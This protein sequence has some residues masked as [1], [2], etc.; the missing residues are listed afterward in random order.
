VAGSKLQR[1]W[2]QIAFPWNTVVF[3]L[4]LNLG[5]ALFFRVIDAYHAAGTN[6]VK[7]RFGEQLTTGRL[8]KVY[9]GMSEPQ[10]NDLLNETW[11]R[12][13]IYEPFTGFTEAVHEGEYVNV[14][15]NGYRVGTDQGPWPPQKQ[16]QLVIFLF[17]GSTTFSYGVPDNLALGSRLQDALRTTLGRPVAVYNFGRG[18]YYSTQERIL[19]EQLVSA[20]HVPDVAIF[21]DG[22]NDFYHTQI[23]LSFKPTGLISGA[24]E[25]GLGRLTGKIIT[26]LAIAGFARAIRTWLRG[27]VSKPTADPVTLGK[28]QTPPDESK[29]VM[30]TI[31]RYFRN[32]AM[33]EG[34]SAATGVRPVFVWQP[35]PLYKYD[36]KYHLFAKDLYWPHLFSREGYPIMKDAV[37]ERKPKR[38]I[39][40]ADIQNEIREP[41]YVD[42]MHYSPKMIGMVADCIA[43]GIESALRPNTPQAPGQ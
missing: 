20:G 2:Y 37:E 7:E 41:L 6:P 15:E 26:S 28:D 21:V 12:P 10:L 31:E 13:F 40:C 11:N 34:V 8:L 38:L 5:F 27:L 36:L 19:F 25:Q 23:D 9:P 30:A 17:G 16:Q 39:W 18:Y 1:L 14:A 43:N 42:P 4:C 32:K 35:V 29:L 3:I 22:I 24:D 33:I